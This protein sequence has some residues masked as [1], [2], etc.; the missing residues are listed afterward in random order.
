[1]TGTLAITLTPQQRKVLNAM[2]AHGME[3]AREIAEAS[4]LTHSYV[5]NALEVLRCKGL[6]DRNGWDRP[7]LWRRTL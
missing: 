6:V 3:T 2:H 5:A 1:M 7:V 4:G